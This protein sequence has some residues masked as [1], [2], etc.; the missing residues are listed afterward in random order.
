M[1][2]YP[3]FINP[4]SYICIRINIII[5]LSFYLI[6]TS[7]YFL[8]KNPC[9]FRIG[10]L[11][12]ILV[13]KIKL[14]LHNLFSHAYYKLY[15]KTGIGEVKFSFNQYLIHLEI[16]N[17]SNNYGIRSKLFILINNM[18]CMKNNRNKVNKSCCVFMCVLPTCRKQ[19]D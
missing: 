5:F 14:R 13:E 10:V 7:E 15:E 18:D 19:S 17:T 8:L 11:K 1:S 2:I 16:R 4:S 9:R 12:N 6:I 3:F